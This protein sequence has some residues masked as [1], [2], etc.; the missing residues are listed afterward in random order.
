[1]NLPN[2]ESMLS[3][4][5]SIVFVCAYD[6]HVDQHESIQRVCGGLAAFNWCAWEAPICVEH[7]RSCCGGY[8]E[9]VSLL[10]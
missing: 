1:M 9:N 6:R 3:I 7:S 4:H 5:K 10:A 2:Y 8:P